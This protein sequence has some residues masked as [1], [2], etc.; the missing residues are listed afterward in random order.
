M[1]DKEG[2][3]ID[4]KAGFE[5]FSQ[6]L[7]RSVDTISIIVDPSFEYMALAEKIRYIVIF[8]KHYV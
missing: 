4:M 2:V 8:L 1:D 7:E 3:L 6:G 5:N